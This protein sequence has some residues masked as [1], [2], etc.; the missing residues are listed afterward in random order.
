MRKLKARDIFP[1]LRLVKELGI[2]DEIKAIA[3]QA[4]TAKEAADLAAL[5]FG[6]GLELVLN[7]AERAGSQACEASLYA[8]LASLWDCAQEEAMELELDD[9]AAG[10]K[11]L[12]E[13]NNF[14][15][16]FRSAAQAMS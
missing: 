3:A 1:F 9:V 12:V 14:L 7:L 11:D 4:N 8:L 15:A 5:Q 13:A 16:F 6:S 2:R 10:L